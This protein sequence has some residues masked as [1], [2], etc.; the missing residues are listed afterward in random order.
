MGWSNPLEVYGNGWRNLNYSLM[1][2]IKLD[3]L[4][5]DLNPSVDC[6][7]KLLQNM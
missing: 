6:D 5:L 3:V 1:R 2:G 7:C 4:H